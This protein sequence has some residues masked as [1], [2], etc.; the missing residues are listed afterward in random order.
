MKYFLLITLFIFT[1]SFSQRADFF[2]ED[3]TFRLNRNHFQVEGFYWFSNNSDKPVI[4]E[5]FYPFPNY[6]NE[7]IDSISVF[8]ISAGQKLKFEH[9]G[10]HGVTF[11]LEVNPHDS[12]LIRVTYNQVL[13]SDSAIYILRTTKH[14]GKPLVSAEYKLII[15]DTFEIR[16]FSYT[17][18]KSYIIQNQ[19]IFYWKME[20]FMPDRDMIFC[21]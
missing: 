9:D 20:H 19:K 7:R 1:N 13:K 5:I 2:K 15:P 18:S 4:S 16:A 12:T 17:P 8:S 14:W 6:S 21:F 3:I 10:E 11:M